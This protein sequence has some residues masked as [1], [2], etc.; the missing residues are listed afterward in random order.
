MNF[1]KI[2]H[3]IYFFNDD[4]TL[5]L[6]LLS[7]KPLSYCFLSSHC[8]YRTIERVRTSQSAFFSHC[9]LWA[10]D[11]DHGPSVNPFLLWPSKIQFLLTF[12][13]TTYLLSF[14]FYFFGKIFLLS[15]IDKIYRKYYFKLIS[16]VMY[17]VRLGEKNG[18]MQLE[19]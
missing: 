11:G 4:D 6:L 8:G 3:S 10:S 2:I 7:G 19:L 17:V 1:L 15:Y 5:P 12:C 18:Q 14:F 9:D 13:S 16:F